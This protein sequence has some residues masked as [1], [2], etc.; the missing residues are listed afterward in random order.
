MNT[1]KQ[2]LL[3]AV[4]ATG[5]GAWKPWHGGKGTFLVDIGSGGTFAPTQ[6]EYMSPTGNGIAAG[7]D[8][9][10]SA[11]GGG[12]FELPPGQVRANI[13]SGSPS[14]VTAIVVQTSG[15]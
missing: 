13:T 3:N 4:S 8:T 7:S 12:N 11:V 10:L 2:T 6:L 9:T 1:H 15:M 14:L 5:A